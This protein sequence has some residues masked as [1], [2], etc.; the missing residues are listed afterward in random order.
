MVF[1]GF[2][3]LSCH[4]AIH[5]LSVTF[6]FICLSIVIADSIACSEAPPQID[7]IRLSSEMKSRWGIEIIGVRLT[8]ADHL[9]DFRYKVLDPDKAVNLMKRG[10]KAFLIDLATGLKLPVPV[11]KVGPMRGT[12]TKP[13]AGR[14]YAIIFSN[15]GGIVRKGNIVSVVI[16]DFRADKLIVE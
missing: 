3:K 7:D 13:K 12:G 8:A 5:L 16:G 6:L 2:Y 1:K 4:W 14:I 10:D 15:G 11:T 9:V